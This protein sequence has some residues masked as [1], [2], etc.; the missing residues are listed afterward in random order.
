M[1]NPRSSYAEDNTNL[2]PSEDEEST[3]T[4][5]FHSKTSSYF[6]MP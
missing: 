5:S 6:H 4:K 1:R 2:C 3:N